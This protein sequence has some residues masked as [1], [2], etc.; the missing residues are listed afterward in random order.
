MFVRWNQLIGGP[1]KLAKFS[2]DYSRFDNIDA[3]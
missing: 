3:D 2:T 1:Q